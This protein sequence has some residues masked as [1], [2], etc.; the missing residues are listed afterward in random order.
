MIRSLLKLAVFLVIGILV[1]NYF[2]GTA[3]EKA[4]S[5]EVFGKVRD[6]GRDAWNLLRTEKDKLDEGK[7]D[8]AVDQVSETVDGL[9]DLLGQLKSSAES[10]NNS[11][12]LHRLQELE[13]RRQTLEQQLDNSTPESYDQSEDDRVR[14]ELRDLLQ[15]TERLMLQMEEGQ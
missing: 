15:E 4:Q 7:Y 11:G 2:Y 9:G 13:S 10:L 8:G 6:L 14:T 3:E 1:Y 5:K 12:A